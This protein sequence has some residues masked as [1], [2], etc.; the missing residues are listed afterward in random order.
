MRTVRIEV[1][2]TVVQRQ[3]VTLTVADDAEP[4]DIADE[5]QICAHYERAWTDVET[6]DVSTDAHALAPLRLPTNPTS[7]GWDDG[8]A[9]KPARSLDPDYTAA[10]AAAEAHF[11][12]TPANP[13]K[14]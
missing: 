12:R 9:G 5:A 2:R 6:L 14:D 4:E 7:A 3:S 10:Y 8:R 13:R 1:T 11:T